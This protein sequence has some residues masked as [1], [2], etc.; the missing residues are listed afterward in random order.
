MSVRLEEVV[1]GQPDDELRGV[2]EETVRE[3]ER[4]YG[5]I[6]DGWDGDL[7]VFAGAADVISPIVERTRHVTREDVRAAGTAPR[8]D[9]AGP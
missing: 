5:D 9:G 6:I 1:F 2:I 8:E 3:L 4:A 7:S